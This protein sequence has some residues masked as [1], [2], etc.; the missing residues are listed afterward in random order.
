MGQAESLSISISKRRHEWVFFRRA[1]AGLAMVI[2]AGSVRRMIGVEM[3]AIGEG[4]TE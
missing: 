3:F 2:G 4:R 1:G